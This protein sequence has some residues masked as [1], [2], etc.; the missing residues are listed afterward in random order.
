[1]K[2]KKI[3][4][5]SI[6]ILIIISISTVNIY[7]AEVDYNQTFQLKVDGTYEYYPLYGMSSP[8]WSKYIEVYNGQNGTTLFTIL[9]SYVIYKGS[10]VIDRSGAYVQD[11]DPVSAAAG[12]GQYSLKPV[13]T[14]ENNV[15]KISTVLDS[16]ITFGQFISAMEYTPFSFTNGPY[17]K[18]Y[19]HYDSMDISCNGV[20][21]LPEH[22]IGYDATFTIGNP[23]SH[24]WQYKQTI[25]QATC[26]TLGLTKYECQFCGIEKTEETINPDAHHY[27]SEIIKDA[28]CDVNGKAKYTCELCDYEEE[29]IIYALG[30]KFN[31]PTCKEAAKCLRCNVAGEAALGHSL[32]WLGQCSRCDY[33]SVEVWFDSAGKDI[34]QKGDDIWG[35]MTN[36]YK[37]AE[38]WFNG[39]DF[40]KWLLFVSNASHDEIMQDSSQKAEEAR[41]FLEQKGNELLD[42]LNKFGQDANS[43]ISSILGINGSDDNSNN[44]GVPSITDIINI[45]MWIL[46]ILPIMLLVFLVINLIIKTKNNIQSNKNKGDLNESN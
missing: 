22:N 6:L 42:S 28:T 29:R 24:L 10:F 30:H 16:M 21:M 44:S 25:E 15:L 32:D 17:G 9:D 4:I 40:G 35:W 2:D 13:Y 46:F 14:V 3:I 27:I 38:N 20:R 37:E 43:Y 34:S 11:D 5:F 26:Q 1:M 36:G 12:A 18:Q 33:N 19:I 23:C 7:A 39:T 8:T 31:S 45:V 41:K